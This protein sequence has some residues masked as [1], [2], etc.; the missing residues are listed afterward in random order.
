MN[1]LDE[2]GL[3]ASAG[4]AKA[5][6]ELVPIGPCRSKRVAAPVATPAVA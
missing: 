6:A 1:R 3:N 4:W 2:V 5:S